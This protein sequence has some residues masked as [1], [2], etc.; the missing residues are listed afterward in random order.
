MRGGT[1]PGHAHDR[2]VAEH[3][4]REDV[5]VGQRV[6][7]HARKQCG[8]AMLL[9]GDGGGDDTAEEQVGDGIASMLI[10]AGRL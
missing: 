2:I 7:R 6:Q 1:V 8:A 3:I 4:K 9:R 10:A 5:E